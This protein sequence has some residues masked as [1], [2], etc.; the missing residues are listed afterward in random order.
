MLW[1]CLAK[2]STV[3]VGGDYNVCKRS[4]G[5]F[6]QLNVF[7]AEGLLRLKGVSLWG[8]VLQCGK[9]PVRSLWLPEIFNRRK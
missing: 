1:L 9:R 2:W 4:V 6:E 3:H 5:G 8:H 7:P